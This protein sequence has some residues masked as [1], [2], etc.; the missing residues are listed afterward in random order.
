M[1]ATFSKHLDLNYTLNLMEKLISFKSNPDL[2]YRTSGSAA[3]VAAG[4]FLHDEMKRIGLKN[5]HKDPVV[6][7]NFEFK[8]GRHFL[9]NAQRK[10][11]KSFAVEFPSKMF[12]GR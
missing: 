10:Y 5:V 7:D 11:E 9:Q 1:M 6:V 2:G 3:E 4:D 12:G 8:R